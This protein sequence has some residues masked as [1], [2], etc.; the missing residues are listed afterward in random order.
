M[1]PRWKPPPGG[2]GWRSTEDTGYAQ[3]WRQ[4]REQGQGSWRL[5]GGRALAGM[6]SWRHSGRRKGARKGTSWI[7]F[8]QPQG[9]SGGGTRSVCPG[10]IRGVLYEPS[11]TWKALVPDLQD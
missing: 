11:G 2:C 4:G 1:G 3:K 9:P 7:P 5:E 10:W 8:H 6:R